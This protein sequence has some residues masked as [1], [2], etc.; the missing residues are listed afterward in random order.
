MSG[1]QPSAKSNVFAL[2]GAKVNDPPVPIE[3]VNVVRKWHGGRQIRA[4]S[5]ELVLLPWVG[6]RC[7]DVDK[8]GHQFYAK[9]DLF[10]SSEDEDVANEV[11]EACKNWVRGYGDGLTHHL[12]VYCLFGDDQGHSD[13]DFWPC[14][15]TLGDGQ[16]YGHA[17]AGS[18]GSSA[19]GARKFFSREEELILEFGRMNLNAL[20]E[21]RQADAEDR[22]L[23]T[24]IV[25]R[26]QEHEA[27]FWTMFREM[28]T[29]R[30]DFEARIWRMQLIQ[31]TVQKLIERLGKLG[32][33]FGVVSAKWLEEKMRLPGSD[34]DKLAYRTIKGIVEALQAN[35][36]ATPEAMFTMLESMGVKGQL[37]E[38]VEKLVRQ[39]AYDT[40]Q[41]K[42]EEKIVDDAAETLTKPVGPLEPIAPPMKDPTPEVD[43]KK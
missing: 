33:Y 13:D 25:S 2:N 16:T 15:L 20:R 22:R 5:G 41:E 12:V 38:D 40:V 31:G 37:K 8:G 1:A 18:F 10:A 28:M 29:D 9:A 11:W 35:G 26:Y 30:R 6:I 43:P 39:M 7:V 3:L 27:A 32:P 23:L 4:A 14:P 34:R 21:S 36:A 17:G 42:M 24:G 19:M